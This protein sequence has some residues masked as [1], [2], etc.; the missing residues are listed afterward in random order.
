[1]AQREGASSTAN[2]G[3]SLLTLI[4]L[5]SVGAVLLFVVGRLLYDRYYDRYFGV[6]PDAVGVSFQQYLAYAGYWLIFLTGCV[7]I[8]LAA[9]VARRRLPP[10]LGLAGSAASAVGEVLAGLVLVGGFVAV[11]WYFG[12]DG[13]GSAVF[14]DLHNTWP[15]AAIIVSAALS[16]RYTAA[17]LAD[18]SGGRAD[19]VLLK[20]MT[21]LIGGAFLIQL[22]AFQMGLGI[23]RIAPPAVEVM[24]T[25]EVDGERHETC[26]VLLATPGELTPLY[27]WK[28]TGPL[29][30]GVHWLQTSTLE[31][32]YLW[33]AKCYE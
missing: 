24:A 28:H 19:L 18:Q 8:G 23:R 2:R 7:A 32:N 30:P 17:R 6:S 22:A 11:G 14:G 10:F 3:D 1:M 13:S 26:A 15:V 25:L 9:Q 12:Y 5:S 16:V 21:F 31:L 27:V 20:G 33:E 4:E 29:T